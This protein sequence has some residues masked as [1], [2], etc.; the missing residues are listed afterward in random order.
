MKQFN[1]KMITLKSEEMDTMDYRWQLEHGCEIGGK[2]TVK[3]HIKIMLCADKLWNISERNLGRTL[4][5]WLTQRL[6]LFLGGVLAKT[7]MN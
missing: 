3:K 5:R 1:D 2:Q 6:S 4:P 7:Y